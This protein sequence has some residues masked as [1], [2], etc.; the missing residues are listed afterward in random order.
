MS[1]DRSAVDPGGEREIDLGRWRDAALAYWWVAVAGLAVGLILSGIYSLR[2]TPSRYAASALV[3]RGQ[4][5]NPAGTGTVLGYLSSPAAIQAY[6]TEPATLATVAAKVGITAGELSGHVTTSTLTRTGTV[7]TVDTNS[8]LV[9]LTV[10]LNKPTR[11]EDAANALAA[12]IKRITT[13]NY[14]RQSI[15][16]FKVRLAN[17]AARIKTLQQRVQSLNEVVDHSTGL[18]PLDRLVLVSQLDESEGSLGQTLDA[19]TTAQQGL[20][21]AEDVE[22]TQIIQQAKA[23]KVPKP[24]HRSAILVGGLIGLILGGIGAIVYGLRATRTR[25]E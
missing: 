1:K 3:A 4:A 11:A 2:G 7:S 14:V 6:A 24:A 21:L 10:T 17:Y 18:Q 23:Q 12:I 25:P 13:S 19:Q 8:I 16:I 15:T 9:Q 22:Q 5:F 20:T